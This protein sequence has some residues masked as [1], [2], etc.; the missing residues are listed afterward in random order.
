MVSIYGAFACLGVRVSRGINAHHGVEREPKWECKGNHGLFLHR[1]CTFV[2]VKDWNMAEKGRMAFPWRNHPPKRS[3]E[4]GVF[5]DIVTLAS[6][7]RGAPHQESLP[8]EQV[9]MFHCIYLFLFFV[10]LFFSCFFFVLVFLLVCSFGYALQFNSL[11]WLVRFP[12]SLGWR[13]ENR[14]P[15]PW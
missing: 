9:R 13:G 10:R 5:I 7:V 11:S 12:P 14:T 2:F 6:I 8:S 15:M 4:F 1:Q 3:I